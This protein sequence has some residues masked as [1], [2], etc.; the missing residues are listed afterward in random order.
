MNYYSF[1]VGDYRGATAH[2]RDDEDLCYRR[3][4]D[5]YYDKDGELPDLKTI[6]RRVRFSDEIVI[7]ILEE[8]F[9]FKQDKWSNPRADKEIGD[10]KV[11]SKAGKKGARARWG[12]DGPPI[13]PPSL[14]HMAYDDPPITP[15]IATTTHLPQPTTHTIQEEEKVEEVVGRNW[16]ADF[17]SFWCL[18]PEGRKTNRFRAQSEWATVRLSLPPQNELESALQAFK[19]SPEWKRESGKFIPSPHVFLSERRWQDAPVYKQKAKPKP[20]SDVDEEDALR[21]RLK[22]YP[23]S[24]EIHP[25]WH[26]FPFK[27]WPEST[28]REYREAK[29]L[30]TA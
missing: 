26:T 13:T 21:W 1:H 7:S 29:K 22:E 25:T 2:L 15:P 14:P 4:L 19:A 30:Q 12:T 18:Y 23:D 8:F 9:V 28:R 24:E 6:S 10:F 17:E 5:L 27:M 11:F 3:L 16:S 20:K